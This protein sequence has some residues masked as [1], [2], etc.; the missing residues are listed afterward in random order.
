MTADKSPL[1][2]AREAAGLSRAQLAE[3]IET[4]QHHVWHAEM[5]P[6]DA[7]PELIASAWAALGR[8]PVSPQEEPSRADVGQPRMDL[9][10]ICP[11]C[12]ATQ[13][14]PPSALECGHLCPRK[15]RKFVSMTLAIPGSG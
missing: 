3:K 14:T 5:P 7:D 9:T 1:R 2:V 11:Q 12:K 6:Y 15:G 8:D 13:T 4:T 10:W